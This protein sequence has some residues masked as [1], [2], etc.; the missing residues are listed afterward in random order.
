[1]N[2]TYGE[3]ASDAG[4]G[5]R[6]EALAAITE[7]VTFYR[8]LAAA[9]PDVYVPHLANSLNNCAALLAEV[10]RRAGVLGC[11]HARADL[12]PLRGP[13]AIGCPAVDRGI[14]GR[15]GRQL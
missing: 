5:R 14:P 12:R 8:E 3:K 15:R 7:A 4:F 2:R 10:G 11:P 13:V 1:M 9:N 6:E